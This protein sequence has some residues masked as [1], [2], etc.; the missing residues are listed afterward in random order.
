M[1]LLLTFDLV[2]FPGPH[3]RELS[4]A[5]SIP[6]KFFVRTHHILNDEGHL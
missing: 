3:F 2:Y 1:S 5:N 4:F 6:V